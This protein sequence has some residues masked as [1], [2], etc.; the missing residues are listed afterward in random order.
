MPNDVVDIKNGPSLPSEDAATLLAALV[1]DAR[2]VQAVTLSCGTVWIKRHGDKGR[3][4]I[5][6]VQNAVARVFR[7]PFMRPSPAET[8]EGMVQRDLRRI[9][10][11]SHAGVPTAAVIYSSGSAIV[12]S[13]IA[14]TVQ[15]RLKFLRNDDPAAHDELLVF[16][17]SELGRLHGVGLCHGRPYPRDMFIRDERLGFIDFE[18]EPEAVMPM[19]TAQARDLWL[20]FLQLSIRAA[21]RRKTQDRAY[22]A[23]AVAAPKAAIA[24]LREITRSMGR[25]LW[26]ARLIGRFH[27]G[28]DL[29]QFILATTYL[30]TMFNG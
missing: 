1:S 7:L 18:E 26:L 15:Q 9:A 5:V 11:Y 17:A 6:A 16:C 4:A 14:P 8:A 24:E 27:M 12:L 22:A 2:R 28:R 13:D 10:K 23:W 25:F 20:L 19:E 29:R 21:D 3:R 30:T